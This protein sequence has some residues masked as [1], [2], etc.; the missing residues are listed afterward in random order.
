MLQTSLPVR[1]DVRQEDHE[2][3]KDTA[4]QSMLW[5]WESCLLK[6]MVLP[7]PNW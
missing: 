3:G 7:I 4:V 1:M 2:E 5:V 6:M